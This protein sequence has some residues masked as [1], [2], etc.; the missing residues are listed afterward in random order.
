M[1]DPMNDMKKTE[2]TVD[3]D[4]LE[5]VYRAGDYRQARE[6]VRK[7]ALQTDLPVPERTRMENVDKA[8]RTDKGALAAFAVTFLVIAFLVLKY[9]I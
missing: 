6:M 9:G 1:I 8:M 5:K 7:M 4:R 2:A 3:I